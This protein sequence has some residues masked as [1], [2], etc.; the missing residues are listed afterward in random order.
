MMMITTASFA[1]IDFDKTIIKSLSQAWELD[2]IDKQ[3]LG[4]SLI[5]LL[6]LLQHWFSKR[7]MK[8]FNESG[9]FNTKDKKYFL[10]VSSPN[11]KLVLKLK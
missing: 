5:V 3:P 11:F 1:Q 8:P 9:E 7:R 4:L 10:I 6:I 2:S